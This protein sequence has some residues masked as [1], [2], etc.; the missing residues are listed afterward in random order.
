MHYSL[1]SLKKVALLDVH[2]ISV[3]AVSTKTNNFPYKSSTKATEA[4]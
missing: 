2:K 4:Y 1:V 3:A